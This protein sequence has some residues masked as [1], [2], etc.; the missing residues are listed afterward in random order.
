MNRAHELL[1]GM[2][3][4][5]TEKYVVIQLLIM[6]INPN[7]IIQDINPYYNLL[8]FYSDIDPI[9]EIVDEAYI[10]LK[11]REDNA[12]TLIRKGIDIVLKNDVALSLDCIRA[13]STR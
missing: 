1:N 3:D 8:T 9:L 4:E 10:T 12:I 7:I 6:C 13:R 2:I 11:V 5:G